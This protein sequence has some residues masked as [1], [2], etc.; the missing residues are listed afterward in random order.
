MSSPSY[1]RFQFL[2]GNI[3]Y[4]KQPNEKSWDI[5][6][7]KQID[8]GWLILLHQILFFTDNTD[9]RFLI[10]LWATS[11]RPLR[12]DCSHK[13]TIQVVTYTDTQT[14]KEKEKSK[15]KIKEYHLQ[16]ALPSAS[17]DSK[18]RWLLGSFTDDINFVGR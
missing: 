17:T 9:I 14:Q 15:R 2:D 11:Q 12:I 3:T 6:L 7:N 10:V 1:K 16:I 13:L 8:I 4:S 18:S 5:F